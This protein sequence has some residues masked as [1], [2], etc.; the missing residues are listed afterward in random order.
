MALKLSNEIKVG[1]IGIIVLSLFVY[2]MNYLK[3][4]SLVSKATTIYAEYE[5]AQGLLRGASIYYNGYRIGKIMELSLDPKTHRIRAEI[6]IEEENMEIPANSQAMIFSEGVMG[7]MSIKLNMGN[8]PKM[9]AN[10]G[11]IEGVVEE[12]MFAGIKNAG[13]GTL[14]EAKRVLKSADSTTIADLKVKL[15]NITANVDGMVA[16]A[17]GSAMIANAN[18]ATAR[19]NDIT[20]DVKG[21]TQDL[22]KIIASVNAMITSLNGVIESNKPAINGSMSNAKKITDSL[23]LATSEIRKIAKQA[24]NSLAQLNVSL[25]NVK[26]ITTGLQN[27]EG[28]A[29]KILKDDALYANAKNSVARLDSAMQTV[30]D[31]LKAIKANPKKYL[32]VKVVVFERKPKVEEGI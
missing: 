21:A 10:E 7:P 16:E 31:L 11:I 28:S 27:G 8:S 6:R 30:D 29:G 20:K 14:E 32:N 23:A 12:G 5:D 24:E 25:E 4:T 9:L 3:G 26:S 17:R 1:I 2:G 13:T 22:D 19:V 15:N 18:S